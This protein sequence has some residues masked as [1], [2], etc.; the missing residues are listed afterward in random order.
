MVLITMEQIQNKH[1]CTGAQGC[2]PEPDSFYFLA[3]QPLVCGFC[4]RGLKRAAALSGMT[5]TLQAE[6]KEDKG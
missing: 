4:P 6:R 5:S 3:L 2:H 1:D